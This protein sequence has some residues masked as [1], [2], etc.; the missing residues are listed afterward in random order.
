[1]I[2][3]IKIIGVMGSGTESHKGLSEPL[4][5]LIAE[6][7]YHLLTGGGYGVMAEVS[8]AFCAARERKG[9][10][11][12]I[13]R[14]GDYPVLDENSQKRRHIKYAVNEWVE[15]PVYTHLPLSGEQGTDYMSRNH[16]NVLTSDIVI[17]LPGGPGTYSEVRL[18]AQYQKPLILFLGDSTI[19]GKKAEDL[20]NDPLFSTY[21][22][23]ANSIEDVRERIKSYFKK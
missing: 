14:S 3:R 8:K 22:S 12:G 21:I 19:N 7:G 5:R 18:R 23:I 11:I 4:G 20:K 10:S 2:R 16:I 9:F 1:M 17:A 6:S 13:I 15:I